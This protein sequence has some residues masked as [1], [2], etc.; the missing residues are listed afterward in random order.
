MISEAVARLEAAAWT[1]GL[2]W[3]PEKWTVSDGAVVRLAP[4]K[5]L[6]E[7]P[8]GHFEG[9]TLAPGDTTRLE[10]PLAVPPV[11][12]GVPVYGEPLEMLLYSVYP[13]DVSIDGASVF[14]DGTPPVAAGPALFPVV[15][16]IGDVSTTDAVLRLDVRVPPQQRA[17]GWL[18]LRLVT[19]GLRHRQDQLEL[20]AA[21]LILAEMVARGDGAEM[22]AR[23]DGAEMVA[24]GDGA[25]TV[26]G[27][28]EAVQAAAALVPSEPLALSPGELD[29]LVDHVQERLAPLAP[30]LQRLDVHLIGHSHIDLAWLW[31]WDDTCEVILR[32]VRSV[33]SLMDDYP[34]MTFTHSQPAGYAVVRDRAPELFARIKEHIATGRWEPA[35]MQWVEADTNIP[36]GEATVRQLVEGVRFSEEELGIKPRVHLAPDTFGHAGNLPQ[37]S[38]SAGA[39][40]YYYHRANPGDTWPAHWWEGQDGSRLLAVYTTEYV[41]D[42]SPLILARH[43]VAG[44]L[45]QGHEVALHFFGIGDHGGGPS[46]LSLERLRNLQG[47]A[48][49]PRIRCSTLGAY[50]DALLASGVRLPT[51]RGETSYIFEGCYTTHADTKQDNRSAENALVTAGAL[52]AVAGQDHRVDLQKSWRD[53]LF[54]QFHDIIDGSAI[55]EAYEKNATETAAAVATA[56]AVVDAALGSLH[57]G[58]D[59]DVVVTNP[60]GVRRTDVVVAP[61]SGSGPVSVV[62][63]AGAR[64]AAQWV[65]GGLCFLAT[66]DGFATASYT[67]ATGSDE[68][69]MPTTSWPRQGVSASYRSVQTDVFD[70]VLREDS[71]IITSLVDR[72]TGRELVGYGMRHRSSYQDTARPDLS[73]NVLTFVEELPHGMSAWHL[74]EV[75][76]EQHLLTG[77]STT[78]VEH[79]PVRLVLDV[80]RTW[81]SSTIRQ[82]LSF[83]RRLPRIDIELDVDWQEIGDATA[84]VPSLK[85]AFTARLPQVEAWF[86]TPYAAVQ[87]PSDGQ[88]TPALR[89][90]AVGGPDGGF[91][92]LN[93]SKYGHDALGGRLRVS[94]I[95]NAYDPDQ[96]PDT[97]RHTIRLALLPY[98]GDWRAAGVVD[99]AT[100]FNQPLIARAPTR[101][102]VA[103]R[104]APLVGPGSIRVGALDRARTGS[105]TLIRLYEAHGTP[106]TVEVGGL[107]DRVWETTVTEQRLRRL[108]VRGGRVTLSFG[109][110]QVRTLVVED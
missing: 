77:A 44:A 75:A 12:A 38:S 20:L 51:H 89:W 109:A 108:D 87:R 9:L 18:N 17:A 15:E 104:R 35:T 80:E 72:R 110:W 6:D 5:Y 83:Y 14:H 53:V 68:E 41:G 26:A 40:V 48:A 71:G 82:R 66:V 99:E 70:V 24:R 105:G 32:D 45:D 31:T 96:Q 59:G 30:L 63:A 102:P 19:P 50:A 90:A 88:E 92:V 2:G 98:V 13:I 79:G 69:P 8:T 100:G 85:A 39:D 58:L 74:D 21:Q 101:G 52:A 61:L 3:L 10:T 33:L 46:R 106:G 43:L 107:G 62:D 81:R 42:L 73:L 94:L 64:H 67:V 97:G 47:I 23:G 60:L 27:G 103:D 54:H 36:S 57:A 78:V 86:E 55:S 91:A 84:G 29:V 93:D 37:L 22:V 76:L 7:I 4:T 65:D 34:E 28:D 16:Q 1:A 11:I 25:E 49:F 56:D 95:R